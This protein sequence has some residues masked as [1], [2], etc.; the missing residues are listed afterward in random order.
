MNDGQPNIKKDILFRV[1]MLYLLFIL[2]GVV[3]FG[4]LIWVQ[5][6]SGEVR[7][8]S[9][10]VSA[11]IFSE[12]TLSAHRGNIL[13]RHGVPFATSLFRYQV[14][15]DFAAQGIDSLETFHEQADSLAG[16]LAAFFKDRPARAYRRMFRE[17]HARRYRLVNPRKD[18]T[19]RSEGWFGQLIDRLAGRPYRI[20]TVYDTLRDHRPVR[21]FPRT[22]DYA[23]WSVLK[24]YPLL[25]WNMGMVYRLVESDERLY[26]FKGLGRRTIGS[27]ATEGHGYGIEDAF[28]KELEGR[29]GKALRQRIAH[30]FFGR[31]A[32]G[33][34]DPVDGMDVETTLDAE[35]QVMADNFL[36][37]QLIRQKA[38]W[39]TSMI[40]KV[41]TGELLA[42]V[43]LDL[44]KDGVYR[45]AENRA[46]KMTMDPGST[47]KLATV[48]TLLEDG[49]MSPDEL[50]DSN[51][52]RPMK[53][54]GVRVVDAHRGDHKVA[55][56]RAVAGSSNIYFAQAVWE[57]Y[58]L[59]GRKKRYSDFLEKRLCLNA[60]M[61]LEMLG[62]RSPKI[63]TEGSWEQVPDPAFK[64]VKMAYGYRVAI[65]PIHMLTLYNA[66]A[67]DGR[68]VA[69]MLV[70]ALKRDGETVREYEERT[71]SRSIC[72]KRTLAIV[73]E[74]LEEVAL[75]GTAARFFKDTSFVKVA[76]KTGTAQDT[77]PEGRRENRYL[78]TMVA[79]FPADNPKY[80][81]LTSILTRRQAGCAY[82][83]A[84]LAGPVVKKMVD[85]IAMHQPQQ[86]PLASENRFHPERIKGGD[87][88]QIAE[89][90]DV[91]LPDWDID[92]DPGWVH[93]RGDSLPDMHLEEEAAPRD[94]IPDV[95]GMGL[96]EALFLLESRG[97]R[98]EVEGQ[99]TV[100]A[101][102]I[103]AR[104]PA[105]AGQK[106]KI[107][108]R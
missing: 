99:G 52:G 75:T 32:G 93:V 70:R 88:E 19:M 51:D 86:T 83:G 14:E 97:L 90:A 4:R 41:E 36:R 31:V 104:Q 91:L 98:V 60:P 108:L 72:S 29:D 103:A 11:K 18:T 2:I 68:M 15:F 58:G 43:N 79:Y 71:L 53:V 61:G 7:T 25:N 22:V 23:E 106:I 82:Y 40:M 67:N 24:E 9:E 20:R 38:I 63:I 48:L 37:E 62:E 94:R 13:S 74:C 39:G 78:G 101:Q 21:I 10:R 77:S 55:L 34:E 46:L 95:R 1:R 33:I 49:D 5:W 73:Q 45:E 44:M 35:L 102:S 66:I 87:R 76:A 57:H 81:V 96:K 84:P 6:F 12:V 89:V 85:Y 80:T 100:Y 27:I 8:N 16:L 3:V 30:D 50:H 105:R 107:K 64:L 92:D 65:A 42:L 69:P 47:F 59:T 17:E 54:G 28:R 26:P 56:K